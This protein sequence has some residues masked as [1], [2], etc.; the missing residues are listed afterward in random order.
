M[1]T[2]SKDINKTLRKIRRIDRQILEISQ[3]ASE[4]IQL[5]ETEKE[6]EVEELKK[7]SLKNRALLFKDSKSV[8][9]PL[10][11]F[12]F[13]SSKKIEINEATTLSLIKSKFSKEEI[14]SMGLIS[15]TES[16]SKRAL[17]SFNSEL[18]KSIDAK[19]IENENFYVTLEVANGN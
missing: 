13:K 1:I 19:K 3:K 11:K 6:V 2:G 17:F 16:V 7:F 10:G 18:L 4:R 14:E 12:G 9:F 8:E 5:L 15:I